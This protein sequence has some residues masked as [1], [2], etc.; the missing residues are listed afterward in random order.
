[1]ALVETGDHKKEK[2][3]PSKEVALLE[4]GGKGRECEL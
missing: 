2:F 4:E 3:D 1:M